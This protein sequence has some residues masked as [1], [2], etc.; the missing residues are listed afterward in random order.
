[1]GHSVFSV[2]KSLKN[3]LNR[4]V[5]ETIV[6]APGSSLD[7]RHELPRPGHSNETLRAQIRIDWRSLKFFSRR[8]ECL[9]AQLRAFT[10]MRKRESF[11]SSVSSQPLSQAYA[12]LSP[13]VCCA[14]RIHRIGEHLWPHRTPRARS[15]QNGYDAAQ[16][17]FA[18]AWQSAKAQ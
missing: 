4:I 17:Q 7:H 2:P 18:L 1:V 14:E 3:D 8:A 10:A 12:R 5:S 11:D 9:N 6:N 16:R 13:C 15:L